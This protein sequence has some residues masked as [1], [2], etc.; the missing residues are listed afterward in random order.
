MSLRDYDWRGYYPG[1]CDHLQEFFIPALRRSIRYDR[2]TGDF[3]ASV[4]SILSP[5]LREFVER[6]GRMR[7]MTGLELFEADVEAIRRGHEG[8]VIR[9]HIQWEELAAGESEA[10]REALA[11]LIAEGILEVKFGAITDERGRIRSR[12]YGEWHQ[13]IVVFADDEESAISVAGSPNASFKALARNR[14]S[15]TINRSWA[16]SEWEQE[17]I[18]GQ[19]A[20][21][22]SLWRS[23]APNAAVLDLPDA[24]EQELLEY[25]PSKEP[26]WDEVAAIAWSEEGLNLPNPRDYQQQAIDALQSNGNRL[27]IKHATGTGK[28]W[29]A[30]FALREIASAGDVVVILAPTKDLIKQW[31]SERNLQRFFP[32]ASIIRCYGGESWRKRLYNALNTKQDEPIFAVSTM[33]NL[34]MES[35]FGLV[36]DHTAPEQRLLIGDEVHNLGSPLRRSALTEFVADGARIGLSATPFRGDEGD[37]VIKSYFG[38]V[39]DEVTLDEAIQE[40]EVLSP[41]EYHVHLVSL[42]PEERDEYNELSTEILKLY[43]TYRSREDQ[44]IPEVADSHG[45]LLEK[46][47]A[48]ADVLKEASEKT[49]VAAHIYS[50]VGEKT[51]VFCNTKDHSRRVCDALDAVS[52]RR[53]GLFFGE[54]ADDQRDRFLSYFEEGF[55]DT[56]VSIDCLTEGVDVPECDSAIIIT[57]STS[58]RESIQRRGRVLRE[59]KDGSQAEIHDFLVLPVPKH[60]FEEGGA[61][62]SSCEVRLIDRELDRVE[63]MNESAENSPENDI[64]I[65]SLRSRLRGYKQNVSN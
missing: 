33:H 23:D 14:E 19:Q 58:E 41:Y 55:I 31:A 26:D 57:N 48:R 24:L 39:V 18:A 27:L 54:H 63:R 44:P 43:Y 59:A 38:A 9:D 11:W 29:T 12:E 37:Q 13:K 5:G 60:S 40:Y 28:T 21:F 61:E 8:E 17:K 22:R 6:G 50:D 2:I 30:L 16:D 7:I 47:M 62:L 51:M 1:H 35:V 34:T 25:K 52:A 64:R 49:K 53:T 10:I 45:D 20:E 65:I 32:S 4:L 42:S 46:V 56:L 36:S 3:S 15:I